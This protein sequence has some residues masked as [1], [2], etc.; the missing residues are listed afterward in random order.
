MGER[1]LESIPFG[2]DW[3]AEPP[4][5]WWSLPLAAGGEVG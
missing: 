3:P 4:S 2:W 5:R 1:G